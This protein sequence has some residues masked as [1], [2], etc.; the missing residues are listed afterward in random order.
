MKWLLILPS[1]GLALATLCFA[2]SLAFEH[3]TVIDAT[4]ARPRKDVTVTIENGRIT[5]IRK[6][7]LTKLPAATVT[8]DARG[9]FLIPG[10]WDMHIHLGRPV[11]FLPLLVANGI[12]GIREMYTGIPLPLLLQ[13]RSR[14]DSPRILTSGF[15]DGPP[16]LSVGVPP[17]GAMAVEN[18]QQGHAAVQYL[19]RS[20]YEFLKVYNS[21]PREAYFGIAEEARKLGIPFAGHVPEEVSP[22]EAAKA[23]Q[24]SQE[25][26]INI[27]L[28]CSRNELNLR[29]ERIAIMNSPALSGEERLRLLGFP[30]L[31]GLSDTYDKRKA[32]ALFKLFRQSGTWQT[33]TLVLLKGFAYGDAF[34]ADKRSPL[35]AGH[36]R[37]RYYMKD[38]SDS[39]YR[40]LEQ[41][42]RALLERYKQLVRDMHRARVGLLAGTDTSADNPV[43]PGVG[44]HDEL[45]LLVEA[46]LKPMEALQTATRNPA[47]YFGRSNEFGTV[48]VG[49]AADL[50]LLD[51]D[52]LKDIHNTSKIQAVV[53]RGRYFSRQDLDSLEHSNPKQ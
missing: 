6:P 34:A 9:K 35:S 11:E 51:A 43:L 1:A 53:L 21:L 33:P 22:A 19:A 4:G 45:A 23:G 36:P 16:M 48:E 30:K 17:P 28:A 27:L 40:A 41:R 13:W 44:L 29:A 47:L 26:L 37:E 42:I 5:S 24:R 31:E 50:V 8:V 2:D 12:T 20:G 7:G 10:L 25:H 49:K 46:G 39:E 3:V 14:S 38:L 15:L 32:A 52:P 18:R